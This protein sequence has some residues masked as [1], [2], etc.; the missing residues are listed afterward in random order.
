LLFALALSAGAAACAGSDDDAAPPTTEA[1][2]ST[3]ATTPATD[4]APDTEPKTTPDTTPDTEPDTTAADTT[5]ETT[6]TVPDT[7]VDTPQGTGATT[8]DTIEGDPDPTEP[9]DTAEPMATVAGGGLLDAPEGEAFYVA[10]DPLPGVAPGDLIWARPLDTAPAGTTAWLVLY[11]SVDV[12]GD[13]IP[14]SGIV[15]APAD[16]AAR[17]N[18]VV[19][20]AH[21]TTGMADKCAPTKLIVESGGGGLDR[22]AALVEQGWTYVATDYEGL[23]TEGVH[24]Y[25]VGLS[26]GRGVLDIVRAAQQLPDSGVLPE[27]QIVI[28]GHSQGG[29]AALMTGDIAESYAPELDIVG[30]IAAAPAGELAT[31]ESATA[32]GGGLGGFGLMMLAGFLDAYP[33]LPID[34]VANDEWK[35]LIE[36]VGET[37]TREAFELAATATGPRPNGAANPEWKAVLDGNSPGFVLPVAPVLIVH[38]DADEVVPP[39]LSQ[40]IHD[41]YCALGTV[42]QRTM[43]PGADHGS[44]MV[45]SVPD[46]IS[47]INDRLA[48][49]PAPTSC[50]A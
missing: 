33:Q 38:G 43:Y 48:G 5:T 21:G 36:Q 4:A 3:P 26:E 32:G 6:D 30:T 31:I 28:F 24:P 37:C 18:V 2:T 23:G 40:L 14:V 20:W 34:A 25:L 45:D 27:S 44:V 16:P 41:R 12:G 11:R 1:V 50:P 49:A 42:S 13:P 35:P 17:R 7:T 39:V 9:V 47:W 15:V 19:T 8:A 29:H 10:P 22:A 46:V